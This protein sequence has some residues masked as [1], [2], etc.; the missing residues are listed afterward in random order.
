MQLKHK[1]IFLFVLCFTLLSCASETASDISFQGQEYSKVNTKT[2]TGDK[3]DIVKYSNGSN[4]LYLII[5]VIDT[6]LDVFSLLYTNTFKAQGFSI[7]SDGNRHIGSGAS[8][9]VYITVSPKL[10]ALSIFLTPKIGDK[11]P[12]INN[13]YSLFQN[14]NELSM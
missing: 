11:K 9:F 4:E 7:S 10:N 14:L 1:F 5:P 13:S 8:N 12:L 3:F 6:D 2:S